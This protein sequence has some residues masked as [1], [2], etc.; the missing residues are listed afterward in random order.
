[1]PFCRIGYFPAKQYKIPSFPPAVLHFPGC[2]LGGASVL[3]I[4]RCWSL[5][6]NLPKCKGATVSKVLEKRESKVSVTSSN[7]SVLLDMLR[8]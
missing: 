5:F 4:P 1:M 3:I 6:L 8:N 7:C 2:S